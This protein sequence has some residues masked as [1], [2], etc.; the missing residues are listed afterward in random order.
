MQPSKQCYLHIRRSEYGFQLYNSPAVIVNSTHF[1]HF[2]TW[3]PQILTG[4]NNSSSRG[5]SE[6]EIRQRTE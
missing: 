5:Q 6:D 1:K 2:M 4:T 3:L